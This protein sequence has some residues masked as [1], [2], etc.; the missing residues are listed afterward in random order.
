MR[1]FLKK[2]TS[3]EAGNEKRPVSLNCNEISKRKIPGKFSG[4]AARVIR[5]EPVIIPGY[6]I[7]G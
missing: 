5:V 7:R 2:Q 4:M 6:K 3:E 1:E